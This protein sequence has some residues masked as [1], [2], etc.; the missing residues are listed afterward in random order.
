MVAEVIVDISAGEVDRIFDYQV[1]QNMDISIGDRVKINFGKIATEG[2]VVGLKETSSYDKLKDISEKAD[3]FTS[4][5]PEMIELM[6]FM[7]DKYNLRKADILRLFVPAQLRGGRIKEKFKTA[8]KLTSAKSFEEM[9]SKTRATAVAQRGIIARLSTVDFEFSSAIN[10]EF[11]A[12]ALKALIEK[13]FVETFEVNVSRRPYTALNG[14]SRQVAL[15][16]D[17]SKAVE[18]IENGQGE[19]LLFGVTG[20][21]KTEVYLKCIES[22]LEKGKTAIMLVPEIS[23]TPQT[24]NRF[25]GR[26]GD[27]VALLHSGLS[28]GERLDEWLRLLRGQ[29]KIAVGARSAIFAPLKDVGIIIIDEEHDGSYFSESNPRYN[30]AVVAEFRAKYNG[31][32][33]VKGSATP[34]IGSY[35][36]A[37]TGK[38]QLLSM[39]DRVN[40]RLMPE[41]KI[42]DMC[43]EIKRG[44]RSIFSGEFIA[45]L[46]RAL[47]HGE[48]AMVF[49]NRRGYSSFMMCRKCGY[50]LKCVNCDVSMT[51]H[52][53]DGRMKCHYCGYQTTVPSKC[54]KC[55]SDSIRY[56]RDGTEKIVADLKKLYP[57]ARFL[58][59]DNDT[60]HGKSSH[61]SILTSFRNGEAD[62]L[63]GTQMIAKG[64]DFPKVTFVG[65][66]DA[67]MSLYIGDYMSIERT[68]Q[69]V[70]QVAGRAGRDEL[71]GNVVLQSYSPNHYVFYFASKYDY[72]GFYRKEINVRE[73]T[74]FPPFTK[75]VR[76][77]FTSENED[78]VFSATKTVMENIRV[79]SKDYEE[80]FVSLKA[81]KS[82]L[83]RIENKFR[84]QIMIKLKRS[85]EDEIMKK[86][87]A[88]VS[89]NPVR[90]V[91]VFVEQ[92]PQNLN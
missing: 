48:Q 27:T 38:S 35:Y 22:A 64:H 75:I 65:I 61:L 14:S 9:L 25:R 20:S 6:T 11:G 2:F 33:L 56:G 71:S 86:I 51:Y 72:M 50:V 67:D 84:Y 77:L 91:S 66:L 19:F 59:M 32:K 26:F 7:Q 31:A 79:L 8:V 21:G 44:N 57:K 73:V 69:L 30:T 62:V 74:K 83:K 63:V 52:K 78:S 82:P 46:G 36:D 23:L 89:A 1:P 34:S 18:S 13:G 4:V 90:D 39:P 81:M 41:I 88:C 85:K 70:T 47:E 12:S 42:V 15:T 3:D 54:P 80:D 17:Q 5:I 45:G 92:D 76:V 43:A 68:F 40:K 87:Y 58:R 49:L 28:A 10:E 53:E 37:M 24:M 60:T 16:E 29:A 55:D